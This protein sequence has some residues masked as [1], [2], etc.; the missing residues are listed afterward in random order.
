TG[1][2]QDAKKLYA[3]LI[4]R[5][6]NDVGALLGLAEIATTERN[7]P[8]ATDY[9]TRGRAA[10]PNDPAPGIALINLQLLRQD[11]KTAVATATQIAQQFPTNTDVLDAEGRAQTAAGDTEGAIATYKRIYEL[12]PNSI[13]AMAGYVA[14]LHRAKEFAKERSVLQDALAR[15]PKN[16]PVKPDPYPL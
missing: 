13:R 10:A 16:D 12:S 7:W 5:Q 1:R 3:D 11:T 9:I 8:E 6:P 2:E 4:A 15:D 14:L